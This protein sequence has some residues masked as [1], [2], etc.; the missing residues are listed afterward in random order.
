MKVLRITPGH[1]VVALV[2]RQGLQYVSVCQR[3]TCKSIQIDL[4]IDPFERIIK[5][6]LFKGA[7]VGCSKERGHFPVTQEKIIYSPFPTKHQRRVNEYPACQYRHAILIRSHSIGGPF[8]GR[9]VWLEAWIQFDLDDECKARWL[10][11]V[12]WWN[13]RVLYP[14][15]LTNFIFENIM[16]RM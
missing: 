4:S 8:I 6:I 12:R 9:W 3:I 15:E 16:I 10:R 5:S 1:G 13:K 2:D 11:K 7:A 14:G